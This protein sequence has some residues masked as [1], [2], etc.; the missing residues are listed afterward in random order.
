MTKPTA[1]AFA[2][3]TEKTAVVRIVNGMREMGWTPVAYSD[4]EERQKLEMC[5]TSAR[6]AD[7]LMDTEQAWLYWRNGELKGTMMFV[8]GNDPSE[9]MADC[10][11]D[12]GE[13]DA[14]LAAVDKAINLEG[15]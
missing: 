8:F 5:Q 14:D 1:Y 4:G 11:M 7:K 15:V 6:I 10:S 13:W 3:K 2:A 9:V 12:D